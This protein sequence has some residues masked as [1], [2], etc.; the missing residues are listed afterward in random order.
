MEMREVLIK[1]CLRSSLCIRY[2]RNMNKPLKDK[3]EKGNERN[4][5]TEEEGLIEA[6]HREKKKRDKVLQRDTERKIREKD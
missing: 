2:Q 6:R 5:M 1:E 3:T 4:R